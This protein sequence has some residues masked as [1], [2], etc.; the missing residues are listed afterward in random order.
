MNGRGTAFSHS[1]CATVT[2]RRRRLD[3][4]VFTWGMFMEVIGV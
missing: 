3:M 2:V 1:L 4:S